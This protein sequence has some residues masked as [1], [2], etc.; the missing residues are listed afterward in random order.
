MALLEIFDPK[1]APRP[2]GID[3]GTTNSL[4]AHV[5][6]E[7]PVIIADCDGVAL[8]PSVVAYLPS[9]EVVVGRDALELAN[10]RPLDTIISVKRLMGRGADDPET[11]RLAPYDFV[12]PETGGPNTV[13]F[14]VA[15]ERVLTP[16][17]VSG[18]ILRSLAA[19]ARQELQNIGGAVIT[20]PA[21]FDDAQRQATKDAARLAG[22]EVLRLLN[23]PTAA[24]L[25]YGLEKNQTG[26]FAVYD[27][28]G[29]TFDVTVLVLDDGVFQVKSTGG[30]SQ[31]GGDDMDRALAHE[32]L[33][34]AGLDPDAQP[35]ERIRHVLDLARKAKH[36]LTLRNEVEIEVS[37]HDR[38]RI[39]RE[40]FEDLIRPLLERTGAAC[41]RAL[42]DASVAPEDLAG[43]ILVGGATRVPAVR[44][45][46]SEL[47]RKEPLADIDPDSVVALGAAVQADLLAGSGQ[48]DDILLLDV[49]P[50][51]LG[52]E[53]GGGVVD[54][55]LPRNSMIPSAARATYTTREDN[56]TG[57]E[58]HVVQGERE[59]VADNRSLA[60][61]T[62]KGIPPM[63][64]GMARLE[65][66]FEVDA[67]G[68][69]AVHARET[70]TG[71][72]Q[73][74][75]VQPSY[76]LDDATVERMLA[77]ALDHGESDLL[78]RRLAEN[79]VEAGRILLAARKALVVDGDLIDADEAAKI[80]LACA[81]LEE[82]ARAEQPSRIQACIDML[83][84]AT[85]AFAARRMDRAI[86][87][88][89]GGR[90]VDAIERTVEHA[91][92]IEYA[93]G[94]GARAVD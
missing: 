42:K 26:I 71:V 89:I 48:R 44:R 80:E 72:E 57:F 29:G 82:A 93:H 61:F 16:V 25:A 64:A 28:G 32:L 87:R 55:I 21:Y 12:K 24:A 36:E 65:V 3:L 17:E 13:R 75:A 70:T 58:I 40:R 27:L 6:N 38:V 45:Y 63:A 1:A 54:R 69:L 76:G 88:A 10:D 56:Q 31:L 37:D 81:A 50:L 14:R 84:S 33:E 90:R 67:D 52:I 7:R 66:S 39:T 15:G 49:I 91:K 53:V 47:F 46:V 94:P 9:G 62:L 35:P 77:E 41:R 4:V 51:S 30:D 23:E 5:S 2:I 83:D 34:K 92:G 8:V 86:A 19:R 43:V 74:I 78:R 59:L 73:K 79:R 11:R 22:L 60:R 18:E 68:L 20:V 85:K